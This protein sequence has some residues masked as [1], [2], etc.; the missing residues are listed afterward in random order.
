MLY[1]CNLEIPSLTTTLSSPVPITTKLYIMHETTYV[2]A[3]QLILISI[4]Y[5]DLVA[6]DRRAWSCGYLFGSVDDEQSSCSASREGHL[7]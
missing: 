5:W 7:E 4:T 2:P 6:V 1:V 3:K